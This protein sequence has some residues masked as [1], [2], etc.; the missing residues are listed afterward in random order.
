MNYGSVNPHG[1]DTYGMREMERNGRS[2]LDFSVNLNPLGIP[3]GVL[4]A[5]RESLPLAGS[6]PDPYCRELVKAI[7]DHEEMPQDFILC[8]NGASE[9][10]YAF[11]AAVR[12]QSAAEAV[13]T[14]SEYASALSAASGITPAR[15]ALRKENG[16]RLDGG[17][18]DFLASEKP[19]VLFLCNPNN[20]NGLLI[21]PG[22][23]RE[24]ADMCGRNGTRLFLDECFL[25]LSDGGWSMKEALADHPGLIILKAMTKNYALA[26]V[27]LGY[28][29][30]A[31]R[32]L[33]GKMA[34]AAQPWNVS[35][36]AQAA[37]I[38]ALKET[39]YLRKAGAVIRE[40]R[41]ALYEALTEA[42]LL[43]YPSDANFLLFRGPSGL[44]ERLRE[45]GILIRNCSNYEGLGDGWYRTA[46]R[47]KEENEIL[48]REIREN[49]L[50]RKQS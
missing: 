17:I 48:I 25:D 20:P 37:G 49:H 18:L 3:D 15:Y 26:G 19:E 4:E 34:A 32:E 46:V 10:I 39:A 24:I 14:F 30:S 41:G 7:A 43:V 22:L 29:L 13:P 40:G 38:A 1:G 50:W 28:C 12:P 11:C 5:M 36:I 2:L 45:R 47:L 33:L 8:G 16:F 27:R 44:D 9:L 42:G 31:D 23:L 35:V 21:R 6:Y